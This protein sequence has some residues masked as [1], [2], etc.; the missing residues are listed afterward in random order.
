[1]ITSEEVTDINTLKISKVKALGSSLFFTRYFFKHQYNRKF[2]IGDHHKQ[3]ADKLDAVMR[4]EIT[5]LIIN[6]AP[7]FGKTELA[8]KNFIAKGLAHNPSAKFIHLSYSDDLALDN[9]E[10]VKDIVNLPAYKEMFPNVVIKRGS[11]SK[12]KWYT[13]EGGGVYATAAGGQVTGFGAGQVDDE[14]KTIDSFIDDISL[15]SGFGGCLVLD[16]PIKPT[17]ADSDTIRERVN[18]R[19]DSTIIN[20]VNSRKTPIII[21]MQRLHEEDL[22]GHVINTYPGKWDVLSLP[23]IIVDEDKPL[24]EGKA[25]WPFKL[26]MEELLLSQSVDP[27]MFSRQYMQNP[28]P[29]EGLL[30]GDFKTYS[31]DPWTLNKKKVSKAYIDTADTGADYLCAISYIETEE[32]AYVTDVLYTDKGMEHTEPETA[33]ML[34]NNDTKIA[35]I[36]SNNGGRG[37]ARTVDRLLRQAGNTQCTVSWFHQSQNKI[38]RINTHS[39]AVTNFIIMPEGWEKKWPL[40][41]K[42]VTSYSAKAKN[43]HDDAQ[44]TLTGIVENK[45]K[46]MIGDMSG[47]K[48]LF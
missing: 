37:F 32:Y 4:G 39:A 21:I 22:C 43:A 40:F 12:K 10:G 45:G 23:A 16:D 8:V 36:E 35:K 44:D 3:I 47:L 7:R 46:D 27:I 2:V 5:R 1:M 13:T 15:M 28:M 33:N 41:Y 14:E 20:R 18:S 6:I 38:V 24:H 34:L 48:N 26:N 11:D 42:H 17:D 30:Y 25:L 19:F 29:R 31:G 9:S